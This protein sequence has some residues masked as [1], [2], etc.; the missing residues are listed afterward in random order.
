MGAISEGDQR[1]P[2]PARRLLISVSAMLAATMVAVDT[3]IAN[4]ALPHMQSTMSAS[5]DE[6]VWVLTSYLVAAAIATPLSGWL[7]SRFGRR[8]VMLWS[9]AG[10]TLASLLCGV[11]DDLGTLVAARTI[12]GI[13]GAGLVP[14][15]QATL[16]DIYPPDKHGKA[17]AVFGLGSLL[18]PIIG[19][20]LGGWLTDYF[21]WR[22]VFFINL[23]LGLLSGVGMYLFQIEARDAKPEKFDLFGFATISIALAAFQLMLDRGQ[24]LDWFDATEVCVYAGILAVSLYLAI[25]HMCTTR[26]S[27]IKPRLFGDRNFAIGCLLSATIGVVA[28]ATIPLITV[29]MQHLLGY[30][31][32]RTGMVSA[33]RGIGTLV[34]MLLV[35]R[36]IGRVDTRLFIFGGLALTAFGLFLYARLDLYA[37]QGAL[38]WAGFVQGVGS[39]LMFVPLSTIVF[40]TLPQALR[41]EGAAMYNLTRNIGSSIGIS[42]LQR[43]LFVSTAIG[44]SRLVEGVRPDS[45]VAQYAAPDMDF[46]SLESLA[47]MNGE[48]ARQASMVAYVDTFALTAIIAALMI[49]AI[50]FLRPPR[51]SAKAEPLP[52]ME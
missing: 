11:A 25:V 20:T 30:T 14:L 3:T 18:G 39:G 43:E 23:L 26:N 17:M 32:L 6:I 42:L 10:F 21:S 51:R 38:L 35:S 47:R 4:V 31:A 44:Q 7:A 28:F 50:M 41:N 8:A 33:P 37:D 1:Y 52:A 40:A 48:V 15:S 13:C 16:L 12:Q 9:I 22:W 29:M 49:P 36:M 46:S 19:P 2:D 5:Q 27:F 34:S 24:Q 45:P